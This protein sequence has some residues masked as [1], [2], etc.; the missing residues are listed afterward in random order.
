MATGQVE[1]KNI[2]SDRTA[3]VLT[4]VESGACFEP[5]VSDEVKKGFTVQD[6]RDMHRMG[7]KQELRV[8][9]QLAP[10]NSYSIDR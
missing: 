1:L 8:R 6:Q 3:H 5:D 9:I 7:K 4:E 2:G 10:H